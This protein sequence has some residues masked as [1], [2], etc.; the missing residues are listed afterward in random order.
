MARRSVARPG[1]RALPVQAKVNTALIPHVHGR[2]ERLELPE[3]AIREALVERHRTP[4]LSVDRQRANVPIPRPPGDRDA[5]RVARGDAGGGPGNQERTAQSPAVRHVPP[6][7]HGGA[8]RQ[9]DPAH[10]PGVPRLR[11]RRA[12]DRGLRTLG[13]HHLREAHRARTRSQL[14]AF[15]AKG[16]FPQPIK[17][18]KKR[19]KRPKTRP[20]RTGNSPT[21]HSRVG[22]SLSSG[23]ARISRPRDKSFSRRAATP[24]EPATLSEPSQDISP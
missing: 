9:W 24:V 13:D 4:G 22:K 18:P 16:P 6:H 12:A 3:D 17:R 10:S 1:R 7:G 14:S 8:D 23:R 5:G 21:L 15:G 11:C 19:T 20:A 2:D